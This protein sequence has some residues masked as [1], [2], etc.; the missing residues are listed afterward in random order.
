MNSTKR[1][2]AAVALAGAA[3]SIASTAHAAPNGSGDRGG[4]V[5][6]QSVNDA[7]TAHGDSLF[8]GSNN[9]LGTVT[10]TFTGAAENLLF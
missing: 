6:D 8:S 2:L 1:V 9:T 5:T 4:E 3:L 10:S 7:L